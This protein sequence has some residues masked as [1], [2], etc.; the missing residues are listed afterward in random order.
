MS[1]RMEWMKDG[2][3]VAIRHHYVGPVISVSPWAAH[4]HI[5]WLINSV[6]D[7]T[8]PIS[9]YRRKRRIKRWP[10]PPD[11][12]MSRCTE[13]ESARLKKTP[14]T[15]KMSPMTRRPTFCGFA[16]RKAATQRWLSKQFGTVWFIVTN[17]L[18]WNFHW[19][20]KDECAC[21]GPPCERRDVAVPA[22]STISGDSP[23][24]RLCNSRVRPLTV[25]KQK[26]VWRLAGASH[27]LWLRHLSPAMSHRWIINIF[28]SFQTCGLFIHVPSCPLVRIH[29]L[30][31]SKSFERKEECVALVCYWRARRHLLSES[32]TF[33]FN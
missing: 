22:A 2:L 7:A 14:E 29:R 21:Q 31:Q 33:W 28:Y 1:Y 8:C 10:L 15:L 26:L 20:T 6:C 25:I 23:Y 30:K 5:K 32:A 13:S 3:G 17:V 19:T 11:V 4:L 27:R 18:C 16:V 9:H 12:I 24:R